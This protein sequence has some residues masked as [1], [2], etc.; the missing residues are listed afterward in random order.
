[1]IWAP[2][3]YFHESNWCKLC[4]ESLIDAVCL[5]G[6]GTGVGHRFVHEYCYKK[7]KYHSAKPAQAP[8]YY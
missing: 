3:G 8:S 4:K 1:M 7:W 2:E 6:F 5:V